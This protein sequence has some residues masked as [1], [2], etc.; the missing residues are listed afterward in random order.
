MN[1]LNWL[2]KEGHRGFREWALLLMTSRAAKVTGHD[3][4]DVKAISKGF[5]SFDAFLEQY[6]EEANILIVLPR[7]VRYQR[8]SV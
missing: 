2:E 4:L 3:D 7:A 1:R 5:E 6:H 8:N